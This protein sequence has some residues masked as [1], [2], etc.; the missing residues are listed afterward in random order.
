MTLAW[1][2][3]LYVHQLGT[4]AYLI[5]LMAYVRIVSEVHDLSYPCFD[6]PRLGWI[7]LCTPRRQVCVCVCTG[8]PALIL[9][10]G[11]VWRRVIFSPRLLRSRRA[12]IVCLLNRWPGVGWLLCLKTC[13]IRFKLTGVAIMNRFED[14]C[15]F[16]QPFVALGSFGNL[17]IERGPQTGVEQSISRKVF[18]FKNLETKI[19][20]S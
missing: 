9:N 4:P 18:V 8:I 20:V 6:N 16:K 17:H 13:Q 2:R 1:Q 19:T 14:L 5:R 12:S 3:V 10:L 7:S 11:V 15:Q